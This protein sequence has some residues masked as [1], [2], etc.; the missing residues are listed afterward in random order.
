MHL[1]S[2]IS[3]NYFTNAFMLSGSPNAVTIIS[4]QNEAIR[5]NTAVLNSMNC[6]GTA[7]SLIECA[8]KMSATELLTKANAYISRNAA[9][10][11]FIGPNPFFTPIVDDYF[12]TD[13]PINLLKKG[14]FKKCP[15][16]T[17]SVSN[18]G[19]SFITYPANVTSLD[20]QL[21]YNTFKSIIKTYF[22]YY[23]EYPNVA[24]DKILNKIT[25]F[26]TN[27]N[28]SIIV[29]QLGYA[30]G[31]FSYLCP[32]KLLSDFYSYYQQ[33][34][35]QYYFNEK[36]GHWWGCGHG[37][38]SKYITGNLPANSTEQD[39]D[40]SNKI[41]NYWGNFIHNNDPNIGETGIN[42]PTYKIDNQNFDNNKAY[43][44]LDKNNFQIG[45]DLK[46]EYCLF[47]E[48]LYFE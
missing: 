29:Q 42:W 14:D 41:I 27:S 28:Q 6:T 4:D 26:H 21:D 17:G 43:M 19:N 46:S 10:G 37:G 2:K 38:E 36:Q 16:I 15:V 1:L 44:N 8:K 20:Q 33:N 7:N 24:T 11:Y 39:K 47:W 12:L 25:D 48:T 13:F 3:S 18:E 22:N 32:A 40:F 9:K 31:D 45:F 35:Y 23:P 5:R 30:A 34:V